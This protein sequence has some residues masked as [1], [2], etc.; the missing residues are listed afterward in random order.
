MLFAGKR[1]ELKNFMLSEVS[2]AQKMKGHI[3]PSYVEARSISSI[4]IDTYMIIYIV[5][6]YICMHTYI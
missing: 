1:M 5:Y 3:F 6:T 2:Q 4:Y